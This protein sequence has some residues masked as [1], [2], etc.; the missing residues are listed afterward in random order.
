MK[1]RKS[2]RLKKE[3]LDRLNGVCNKHNLYRS[4]FV[5]YVLS[6]NLEDMNKYVPDYYIRDKEPR[7]VVQVN[8]DKEVYDA[9]EKPKADRIEHFLEIAIAEYESKKLRKK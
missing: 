1:I 5:N 2:I 7:G 4:S 6:E 8:L 9:I 3:T